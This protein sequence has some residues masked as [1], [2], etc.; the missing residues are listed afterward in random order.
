MSEL[1]VI[2]YEDP[3]K[4]EETRLKLLKLQ[5]DY[6]IDLEDAVVA[7]KDKEGKVKLNQPAP[8]QSRRRLVRPSCEDVLPDPVGE[9]PIVRLVQGCI[10]HGI[11]RHHI[12]HCGARNGAARPPATQDDVKSG[13]P[14][15]PLLHA[16]RTPRPAQCE[17]YRAVCAQDADPQRS[18]ARTT[19]RPT[20]A[21]RAP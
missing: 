8:Q 4:A 3:F 20:L 13:A 2:G 1:I 7:V 16:H 10:A 9:R 6:L 17:P 19:A 5:R 14:H 12:R 15:D 21:S 18:Q 11:Q